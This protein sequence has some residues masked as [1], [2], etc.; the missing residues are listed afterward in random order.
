SHAKYD[1]ICVLDADDDWT[2][3]F[4]E[5]MLKMVTEFPEHKIFSVRHKN[6]RK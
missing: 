1:Y 2:P 4:L 3:D 6:Y 5:V